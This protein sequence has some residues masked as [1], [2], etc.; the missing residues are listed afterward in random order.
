MEY[1]SKSLLLQVDQLRE[2]L[3]RLDL[4]KL[5]RTFFEQDSISHS[6]RL[7]NPGT[8]SKEIRTARRQ[9]VKKQTEDLEN[10]LNAWQWAIANFTGQV[11][12][13]YVESIVRLI[14]PDNPSVVEGYRKDNVRITGTTSIMPPQYIKVSYQMENLFRLVNNQDSHPVE[15]AVLIHFHISRIHPFFDGNGRSARLLQN[16]IL[17]CKEYAPPIIRAEE[18][19]FYQE[20]LRS[21]L[22]GYENRTASDSIGDTLSSEEKL[23]FNYLATKVMVTYNDAMTVLDKLPVYHIVLTKIKDPSLIYGVKRKFEDYFR[24]GNLGQ[25]RISTDYQNCIIVRGNITEDMINELVKRS[26]D[27]KYTV[28]RKK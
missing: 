22:R 1:V 21:A 17:H 24:A 8:T 25:A 26:Y 18:R 28:E 12:R 15:R 9:K 14:E 10:L 2:Q 19:L 3:D 11:N 7:E 13:G 16:L 20:L 4:G 6:E 5:V 23:F 27:H